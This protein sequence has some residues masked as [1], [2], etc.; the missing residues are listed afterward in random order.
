MV[1]RLLPRILV[2]TAVALLLFALCAIAQDADP[3]RVG[4]FTDLHANEGNSPGEGKVMVNFAER[5]TAFAEDM[6][7]WGADLVIQLGDFVNGQYAQMEAYVPMERFPF[8]LEDALA[9]LGAYGGP[10][11]HVIGNHDVYSLSKPEILEKTGAEATYYSFDAGGFHFVILDAQFAKDGTDLAYSFWVIY[12]TVPASQ[13]DWLRDDLAATELPTIVCI[14]QPLDI[15][16][17]TLTGENPIVTNNA[18]VKSVLAES[19]AVIAVLQGHEHENRH[20]VIDG[21]HY[22]T[23]QAMVDHT[24]PTVPAWAR[25]TFDGAAR[26]ISIAGHGDQAD[27]VLDY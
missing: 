14:H 15:E 24:E 8:I 23:F 11:H 26:T 7:A 3:L 27:L 22:V 4:L 19:G 6:N 10:T 17:S 9:A 20:S 21:I 18:E 16:S 25:I 5:L 13:V 12:G 2:A 1:R